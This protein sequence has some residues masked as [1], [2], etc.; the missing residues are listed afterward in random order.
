MTDA[1]AANN[2]PPL[3]GRGLPLG[4]CRRVMNSV[5][6]GLATAAAVFVLVATVTAVAA[7]II[8]TALA[9]NPY[10]RVQASIKSGAPLGKYGLTLT[11]AP[12]GSTLPPMLQM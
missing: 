9:T 6:I 2:V 4:N 3:G 11:S 5:V 7:W 8:N 12:S 10:M 1:T